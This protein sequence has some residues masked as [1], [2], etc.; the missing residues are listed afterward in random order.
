[1]DGRDEGEVWICVGRQGRSG[2]TVMGWQE[3]EER[4]KSWTDTEM[5]PV[6]TRSK[7]SKQMPPF[8]P[9]LFFVLSEIQAILALPPISRGWWLPFFMGVSNRASLSTFLV[10]SAKHKIQDWK[11]TGSVL[12]TV[13]QALTREGRHHWLRWMALPT[14]HISCV[15]TENIFIQQSVQLM[16]WTGNFTPLQKYSFCLEVK[17][18]KSTHSIGFPWY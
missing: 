12:S 1:M 10:P 7:A 11:H 9:C 18:L 16:R 14:P 3:E 6:L 15:S 5:F 13:S 8:P 2:K 17:S 4:D